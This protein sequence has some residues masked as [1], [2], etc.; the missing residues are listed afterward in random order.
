MKPTDT[1]KRP[2]V[3]FSDVSG[4][5]FNEREREELFRLHYPPKKFNKLSNKGVFI[6]LD[7]MYFDHLLLYRLHNLNSKLNTVIILLVLTILISIVFH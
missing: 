2:T 5:S 6:V 4:Q 7:G 1:E 3:N